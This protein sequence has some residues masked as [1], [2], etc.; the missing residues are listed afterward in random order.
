VETR[1]RSPSVSHRSTDIPTFIGTANSDG[2]INSVI[3]ESVSDNI[4]ISRRPLVVVRHH[5]EGGWRGQRVLVEFSRLGFHVVNG[6]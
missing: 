2:A 4:A 5:S 6:F 3:P 1:A